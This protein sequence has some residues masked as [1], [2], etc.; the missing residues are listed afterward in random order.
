MVA[1]DVEPNQTKPSQTKPW[2]RAAYSGHYSV[3][4]KIL[5]MIFEYNFYNC[6]IVHIH[7]YPLYIRTRN[8]PYLIQNIRNNVMMLEE[9]QNTCPET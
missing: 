9:I 3:P 8:S 6:I 1:R 5:D 4:Y 2:H 7:S